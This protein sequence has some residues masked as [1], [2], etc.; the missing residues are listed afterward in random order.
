MSPGRPAS[1]LSRGVLKTA[2]FVFRGKRIIKV[3][4]Q[5][6]SGQ[7]K[8]PAFFAVSFVGVPV[9]TGFIVTNDF[10]QVIVL[11]DRPGRRGVVKIKNGNKR[12]RVL[13]PFRTIRNILRNNVSV[14]E[15]F[16]RFP[17]HVSDVMLPFHR[18]A[19]E[20]RFIAYL[21]NEIAVVFQLINNFAYQGFLYFE[22]AF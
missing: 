16:F 17:N 5:T 11:G 3:V 22:K 14:G 10:V 21:I 12:M 1:G 2:V 15:V 13:Y 6:S 4:V 9:E 7:Y 18:D 19:S 20:V 8:R